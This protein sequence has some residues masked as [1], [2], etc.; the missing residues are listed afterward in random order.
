MRVL[1]TDHAGSRTPERDPPKEKTAYSWAETPGLG[2]GLRG[3]GVCVQGF[4]FRVWPMRIRTSGGGW[5]VGQAK[6]GNDN[7]SWSIK[8]AANKYL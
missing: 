3:F 6:H 7:L 8:R 5:G 4:G 2:I 1:P